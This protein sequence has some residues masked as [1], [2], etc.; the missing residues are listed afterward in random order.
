MQRVLVWYTSGHDLICD[1]H[2]NIRLAGVVTRECDI[3]WSRRAPF[4]AYPL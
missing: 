4:G 3:H 2:S 1:L